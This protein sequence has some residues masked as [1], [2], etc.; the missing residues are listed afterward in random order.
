MKSKASSLE[1]IRQS[2]DDQALLLLSQLEPISA[3]QNEAAALA[4]ALGQPKRVLEWATDPLLKAAA[5]LRLGQAKEVLSLLDTQPQNARVA[6]LKARAAWQLDQ[7]NSLELS[8]IAGQMGKQEGDAPASIAVATLLGE[9]QL[10]SLPTKPYLALRG[11][12]DGLRILELANLEPDAHLQAVLA[13]VHKRIGTEKH[14]ETAQKALDYSPERS[15]AQ[16]LALLALDRAAEAQSKAQ[17]GALAPV[18]WTK[19][20]A[21]TRVI[22]IPI[23]Q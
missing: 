18:W 14:Q 13:H 8:H 9:I 10:V 11:L 6:F 15:P 5:L 21:C 23:N 7:S 3:E 4:L 19:I 20:M 2:P 17:A 16:I 12:A 22:P 1:H